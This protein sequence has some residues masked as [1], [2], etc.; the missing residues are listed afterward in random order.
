M[1]KKSSLEK[2]LG[3]QTRLQGVANDL[4]TKLR[5]PLDAADDETLKI[6]RREYKTASGDVKSRIRA[7]QKL[8]VAL[9]KT[10]AAAF[11]KA[12]TL[13]VETGRSVAEIAS[14]A[15][16]AEISPLLNASERLDAEPEVEERRR[17]L[18]PLTAKQI[19]DVLRWSPIQG[20]SIAQWFERWR[21]NDLRRI[22]DEVQTGAVE[23]LSV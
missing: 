22:V 1:A 2:L 11:A 4:A 13:V 9:E 19:D 14:A 20:A 3:Y 18:K 17:R 23:S 12:E 6:L 10:R 7:I 16:L 15:T 5:E 8:V 21:E